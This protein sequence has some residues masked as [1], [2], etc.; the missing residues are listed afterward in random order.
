MGGNDTIMC[1]H[2]DIIFCPNHPNYWI[3]LLKRIKRH[4]LT[5]FR[6]SIHGNRMRQPPSQE[7]EEFHT[8]Q[9]RQ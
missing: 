2:E 5:P 8:P 1:Y 3:G 7:L 4:D 9:K 6:N